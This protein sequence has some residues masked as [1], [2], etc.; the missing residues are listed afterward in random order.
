[1]Q[2]LYLITLYLYIWLKGLIPRKWAFKRLK[3]LKPTECP[4]PANGRHK[5][6]GPGSCSVE[7]CGLQLHCLSR[8]GTLL[9]VSI[10]FISLH[11]VPIVV[12]IMYIHQ[13]ILKTK[14]PPSLTLERKSE[15]KPALLQPGQWLGHYPGSHSTSQCFYR[16]VFVSLYFFL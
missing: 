14:L 11:S 7:M 12:L 1:M 6:D 16:M 13:T 9:L 15:L 8:S 4:S 2:W 10:L 3:H 5:R